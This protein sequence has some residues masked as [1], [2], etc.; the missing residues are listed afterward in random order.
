LRPLSQRVQN[1]IT[2]PQIAETD[3]T[4]NRAVAEHLPAVEQLSEHKSAAP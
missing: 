4:S 3:F 2:F 1:E